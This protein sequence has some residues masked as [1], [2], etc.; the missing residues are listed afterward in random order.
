VKL[1][2]LSNE[3]L[4]LLVCG[5][6]D[7]DNDKIKEILHNDLNWEYITKCAQRHGISSFLYLHLRAIEEGNLIPHTVM[8]NLRV[9]YYETL[10][11]NMRHF[12]EL[13]RVLHS[14]KKARIDVIVL[15]G[16][17]LVETVYKDFSLRG[18]KDID[19]LVRKNDLNKA[20]KILVTEGYVSDTIGSPEAYSEKFGYNLHY[21]KEIVL[22]LHWA[23]SRKIVNERYILIEIDELWKNAIPARIANEDI[24]ILSPEDML[25]H[26]SIHLAGHRY[27]RLIWF[28]DI[29]EIIGYYDIKWDKLLENAKIYRAKTYLYYALSFTND[30][31]GIYVPL[32]ILKELKPNN[33]ETKLFRSVPE[34]ILH[35]NTRNILHQFNILIK[36][37]LISRSVDRLR[38]LLKYFFPPVEFVAR[39]YSVAGKAIFLYYIAHP[40]FLLFKGGKRAIIRISN[41]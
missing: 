17:A 5:P 6:T 16:A 41:F 15:K 14:F 23:I 33:L 29:F 32:K 9:Q 18:F 21:F 11:R 1:S 8:K 10:A 7:T 39:R 12:D 28:Y 4:L 36:L 3:D 20:K 27:D 13:S 26:L 40:F 24:M 37:F 31:F 38:F 35:N 22:E 34:D 19:I 25:L 30:L 2:S